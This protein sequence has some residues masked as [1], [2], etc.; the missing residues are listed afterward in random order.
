MAEGVNINFNNGI[1]L[2]LAVVRGYHKIVSLIIDLNP[3]LNSSINKALRHISMSTS[4]NDMKIMKCL[5]KAGANIRVKKDY[6]LRCRANIGD[7]IMV[8]EL[9]KKGCD[10]HADNNSI[11]RSFIIKLNNKEYVF[12][13]LNHM[14]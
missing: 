8:E 9:I 13:A 11:L 4:K 10:I 7:I 1:L 14:K 6:L 5:V 2:Y 12:W 3:G